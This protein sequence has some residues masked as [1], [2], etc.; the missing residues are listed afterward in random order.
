[1]SISGFFQFILG[2]FLGVG[3]LTGSAA[4]VAFLLFSKMTIAPEKPVFSEEKTVAKTEP[5]ETQKQSK[6]VFD[7]EN[8]LESNAYR[9]RVTWPDGLVLRGGPTV[10][11]VRLGG[12]S[13]NSEVIVLEHSQDKEWQKIRIPQSNRQGWI[14]SGNIE[15]IS[16]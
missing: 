14:K 9:A 16:Q 5:S 8:E 3:I 4:G 6:T 15:K 7:K 1:M 2:F 12:L 13:Y 10:R 11:A